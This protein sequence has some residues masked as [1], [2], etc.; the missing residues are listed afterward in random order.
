MLRIKTEK[1]VERG[2]NFCDL[3]EPSQRVKTKQIIV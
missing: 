2:G 1:I 3:A